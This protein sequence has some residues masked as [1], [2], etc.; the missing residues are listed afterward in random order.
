TLKPTLVKDW[1][2]KIKSYNQAP[3]INTY[4]PAECTDRIT[5]YICPYGDKL[6]TI[7]DNNYY[8]MP[9]G[10]P[11][12]NVNLHIVNPV[13]KQLAIPGQEG[14]LCVSGIQV[15]NSY[16]N[17]DDLTTAA[18]FNLSDG[19]RCYNTGDLVKFDINNPNNG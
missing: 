1:Y 5:A 3:I 18:T 17:R 14:L 8:S 19:T 15:F 12:L 2:D 11:L 16:L 7:I 10:L 9:I 6:Q 13:T 4:C